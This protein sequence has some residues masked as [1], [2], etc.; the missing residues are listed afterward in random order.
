MEYLKNKAV[1]IG[2]GNLAWHLLEGL[3][4]IGVPVTTVFSRSFEK[5]EQLAKRSFQAVPTNNMDFTHLS[6]NLF[7]LCIPDDALISVVSQIRLPS[8]AI[9]I[10]SSGSMP[11]S[12]L[13]NNFTHQVGVLY[14]LQTFS[15]SHKVEWRKIPIF[16]EASDETT[17]E[18]LFH[19]A[20]Q[21]S[22]EV[23]EINSEERLRLHI[24]AVMASNF[25]N[26]FLYIASKYLQELQLPFSIIKP[27]VEE[28]IQK[29]FRI[30][31]YEAQTGPARQNDKE[32]LAYHIETLLQLGQTQEAH[33]YEM[34]SKSIIRTYFPHYDL[35]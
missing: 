16:V 24:S 26:H 35:F 1:I 5:A 7:F 33:L 6:A 15:K 27:L 32:T 23:F 22:E 28:T 11:I 9:L 18:K 30:G 8:K 29:A 10:H 25:V 14:P 17:L 4:S 13:Q 20:E 21:L 34:V 31:A 3:E 19:V 12:A 2:A